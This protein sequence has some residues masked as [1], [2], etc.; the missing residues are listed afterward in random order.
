MK[1]RDQY[2]ADQLDRLDA[3]LKTAEKKP[4]KLSEAS[5]TAFAYACEV[6]HFVEDTEIKKLLSEMRGLLLATPDNHEARIGVER[7]RLEF[8]S[9]VY[10]LFRR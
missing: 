10:H 3:A 1:K 7:S 4:E 2:L 6:Y 9:N 8:S 5:M